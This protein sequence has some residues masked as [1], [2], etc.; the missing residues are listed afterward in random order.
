MN[1]G[2]ATLVVVVSSVLLSAAP[3]K[4]VRPDG[5]QATMLGLGLTGRIA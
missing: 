2:Q 3:S 4:V 1:A 5:L